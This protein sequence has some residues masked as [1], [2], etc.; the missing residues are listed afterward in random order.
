MH[1]QIL[2]ALAIAAGASASPQFPQQFG[3]QPGAF[4]QQPGAFGQQPGAFGQQPGGFG[5]PQQ[6]GGQQGV[7]SE[8]NRQQLINSP[9]MKL[10]TMCGVWHDHAKPD[11]VA[12]APL[13]W[14]KEQI[15]LMKEKLEKLS[16]H[17]AEQEALLN[18]MPAG[19]G[20][21]YLSQFQNMQF[22]Q[23]QQL[24]A[25]Y[26]IDKAA[27]KA[28][29]KYGAAAAAGGF[30]QQPGAFGQQP[31]AF[32]QQPGAFGQQPGAFGQQPGGFGQQPQ[33]FGQQF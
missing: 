1:F 10:Y 23:A 30:G 32:G 16:K 17:N 18:A 4:G 7:L 2:I 28:T 13:A 12:K 9:A 11:K 26:E 6:F 29:A 14:N 21:Q 22:G 33:Q 27:A 20:Q 24:C 8:A 25:Q 19:K 5:Q 3:Q 15:S 31:G